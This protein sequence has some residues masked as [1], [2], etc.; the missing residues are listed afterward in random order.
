MMDAVMVDEGLFIP[1]SLLMKLGTEN[2]EVLTRGREIVIRPKPRPDSIM[3]LWVSPSTM[4]ISL[5]S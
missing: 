4:K 3:A 1:R 5:K 2:L